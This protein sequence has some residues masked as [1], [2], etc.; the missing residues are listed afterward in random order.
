MAG[1][2]IA[3][4]NTWFGRAARNVS[5]LKSLVRA[6]KSSCATADEGGQLIPS[7]RPRPR[8][9]FSSSRI[10][11][12]FR[13]RPKNAVA[14]AAVDHTRSKSPEETHRPARRRPGMTAICVRREKAAL[15]GGCKSHPANAPAGSNRSSHGGDEMAEAFGVA[16]H[17]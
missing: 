8:C 3:V 4:K 1:K 17:V 12:I 2:A 15:S 7:A 13:P 6:S 11:Q 10:A 5:G 16:G 14:C 9:L